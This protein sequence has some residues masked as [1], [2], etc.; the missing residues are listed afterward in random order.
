MEAVDSL[1]DA[2]INKGGTPDAIVTT[3]RS[4]RQLTTEQQAK[5]TEKR[6]C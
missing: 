2:V 4:A 6:Y 3:A 5:R 1:I